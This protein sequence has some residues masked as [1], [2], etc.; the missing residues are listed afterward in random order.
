MA[1]PPAEL[2]KFVDDGRGDRSKESFQGVSFDKINQLKSAPISFFR[3]DFRKARIA[4]CVFVKSNFSRCDFIASIFENSR[5]LECDFLTSSMMNCVFRKCIFERNKHFNPDLIRCRLSECD[6]LS[7]RMERAA[8]RDTVFSNCRFVACSLAKSSLLGMEFDNCDLSKLNL[9]RISAQDIH[10]CGGNLHGVVFDPDYL[11]TYTFKNVSLENVRFEYRSLKI[12]FS[13]SRPEDFLALG[14]HLVSQQRWSEAFNVFALLAQL[15][16]RQ[17]QHISLENRWERCFTA[18]LDLNIPADAAENVR[19]L[20]RLATHYLDVGMMTVSGSLSLLG[21]VELAGRLPLNPL[22]QEEVVLGSLLFRRGV[23]AHAQSEL[24]FAADPNASA[25]V[26]FQTVIDTDDEGG[27]RKCF[28]GLLR[29]VLGKTEIPFQVLKV[30]VGSVV[31]E[32]ATW[33]AVIMMFY[34]AAKAMSYAWTDIRVTSKAGDRIAEMMDMAEKPNEVIDAMN[35]FRKS[36][37]QKTNVRDLVGDELVDVAK[38]FRALMHQTKLGGK[39]FLGLIREI[40]I[41]ANDLRKT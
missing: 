27:A 17:S 22:V 3:S 9:A 29:G 25:I 33:F 10:F 41:F 5:F 21:K 19:R 16:G 37:P 32:A 18:A 31:I 40:R 14:E 23:E 39:D 6:F 13:I 34:R 20:F 24:S 36:L 30:G 35:Q 8:W 15:H 2:Y 38:G 1:H 12:D 26:R 7:Q 11:G 28:E 4:D